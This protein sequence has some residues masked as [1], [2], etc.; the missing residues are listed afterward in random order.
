MWLH[1]TLKG[2]N[3]KI[4]RK[5]KASLLKVFFFS[6]NTYDFWTSDGG[7]SALEQKRCFAVVLGGLRWL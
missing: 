1:G 4:Q 6:K 5:M 3:N 7:I 2:M